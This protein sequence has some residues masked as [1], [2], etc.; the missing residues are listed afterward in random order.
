MILAVAAITALE[1]VSSDDTARRVDSQNAVCETF[2]DY[3]FA[4]FL[5]LQSLDHAK[6]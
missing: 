4:A 6:R 3:D 2:K 5:S 1:Y